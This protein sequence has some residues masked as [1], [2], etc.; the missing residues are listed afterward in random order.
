MFDSY[1]DMTI[2]ARQMLDYL[3]MKLDKFQRKAE[4][5]G[6]E[7]RVVEKLF[8]EMIACKEMAECIIGAPVNLQQDGRVTIGF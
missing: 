4:K 5:Y 8:D 6:M 3:Q 7:D 2:T 1:Y